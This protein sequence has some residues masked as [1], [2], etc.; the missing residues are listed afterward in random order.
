M[1]KRFKVPTSKPNYEELV[2]ELER[3]RD[4]L[5]GQ[6]QVGF[7]KTGNPYYAWYAIGFC[8]KVN[9]PFPKWLAAYLA[10]CADRMLSEKT[11]EARDLRNILPWVLGLPRKQGPGNPL[12]VD[13]NKH[14]KQFAFAFAV[15]I[16]SGD[17][18]PAARFRACNDT[19]KGEY[20]NVDDR[21]LQRWLLDEFRLKKSPSNVKEWRKV[22]RAFYR[23]LWPF[24]MLAKLAQIEVDRKSTRCGASR[25]KGLDSAQG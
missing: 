9:K 16:E 21:T 24:V 19:L 1:K 11:K 3:A 10:Q 23:P 14:R 7:E 20:A 15:R 5:L 8:I 18:P 12:D 13:R 22:T 25:I 2:E 6:V 4:L 17:E